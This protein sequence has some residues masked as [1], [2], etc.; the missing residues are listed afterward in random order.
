MCKKN[1]KSMDH[2]LLAS[3]IL[4]AFLSHLGMSSVIPKRVVDLYDCRWSS[5]SRPRSVAVWK[6]VPMCLIWCLWREMNYR[7]F[8]NKE[9]TLG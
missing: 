3:A 2:L 8:D 4:S 9:R 7:N 6:M 5:S 1:G